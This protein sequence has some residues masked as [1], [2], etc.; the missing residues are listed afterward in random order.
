MAALFPEDDGL[1]AD[2]VHYTAEGLRRFGRTLAPRLAPA[3]VASS[4][5]GT[6]RAS[7]PPQRLAP[8]A[9]RQTLRSDQYGGQQPQ[10]PERGR[11]AERRRLHLEAA[12]GGVGTGRGSKIQA[13]YPA[14]A[15]ISARR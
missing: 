4:A 2:V 14:P 10:S 12:A 3:L 11:S 7:A 8:L 13:P 15:P 1:F 9:Q 5:A 6:P